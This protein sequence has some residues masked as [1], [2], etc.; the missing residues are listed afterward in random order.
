[1]LR[2]LQI[3]EHIGLRGVWSKVFLEG[4]YGPRYSVGVRIAKLPVQL[5]GRGVVNGGWAV[6]SG[7]FDQVLNPRVFVYPAGSQR[8]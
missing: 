3:G 8:S 1:M 5:K 2:G 4:Q 6:D 7:H